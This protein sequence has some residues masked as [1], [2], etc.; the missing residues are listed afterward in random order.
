MTKLDKEMFKQL[1]KRVGSYAG[2]FIAVFIDALDE[3]TKGVESR[4]LRTVEIKFNDFFSHKVDLDNDE[5][6][7]KKREAA[8]GVG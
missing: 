4:N 1:E 2:L 5:D 7:N 6:L 8:N 3:F